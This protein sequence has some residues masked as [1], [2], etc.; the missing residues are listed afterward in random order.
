MRLLEPQISNLTRT[1]YDQKITD[2]SG[3]ILIKYQQI[4]SNNAH[5]T[6]YHDQVSFITVMQARFN[7]IKSI[8]YSLPLS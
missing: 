6:V 4:Y 3:E 7:I 5:H 8:C 2:Q 1:A